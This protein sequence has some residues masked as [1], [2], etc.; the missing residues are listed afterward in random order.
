MVVSYV[1]ILIKLSSQEEKRD[2]VIAIIL[3]NET[4]NALIGY[5][6][7]S[8]RI[9]K[10]YIKPKPCNLSIIQYYAPTSTASGEELEEFY[11]HLQETMDRIPH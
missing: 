8:D 1:K 10:V 4:A 6:P 11:S 3:T 7:V 9:L 5:D 2:T